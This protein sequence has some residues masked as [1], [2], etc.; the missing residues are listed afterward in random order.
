MT[1]QNQRIE[2]QRADGTTAEYRTGWNGSGK[3]YNQACGGW[4]NLDTGEIYAIANWGNKRHWEVK[5]IRYVDVNNNVVTSVSFRHGWQAQMEWWFNEN[6][7]DMSKLVPIK[8]RWKDAPV[9]SNYELTEGPQKGEYVS[10]SLPVEITRPFMHA[11]KSKQYYTTDGL[12]HDAPQGN[13]AWLT[14]TEE[15]ST[16]IHDYSSGYIPTEAEMNEMMNT[17]EEETTS[18]VPVV[19]IPQISDGVE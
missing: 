4:E 10:E 7:V 2:C 19:T 1:E 8:F 3:G 5:T 17:M 6:D 13:V 18:A 9:G 12:M 16:S 15:T 14:P 11:V